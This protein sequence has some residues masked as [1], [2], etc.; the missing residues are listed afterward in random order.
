MAASKQY[1]IIKQIKVP[2]QGRVRINSIP[3]S[4]SYSSKFKSLEDIANEKKAKLEAKNYNIYEVQAFQNY[5]NYNKNTNYATVLDSM[6]NG[7][8]QQKHILNFLGSLNLLVKDNSIQNNSQ[9]NINQKKNPFQFIQDK[10]HLQKSLTRNHQNNNMKSSNAYDHT[11][12]VPRRKS[13]CCRRCGIVPVNTLQFKTLDY[14]Q[15]INQHY[16]EYLKTLELIL[17]EQDTQVKIKK[18]SNG[19]KF[20]KSKINNAVQYSRLKKDVTSN[21]SNN[22]SQL[23]MI[24]SGQYSKGCKKSTYINISFQSD[25]SQMQDSL[26]N[27][28]Q[29]LNLQQVQ[30]QSE[31]Q[32]Q[33]EYQNQE[34]ENLKLQQ[35]NQQKLLNINNVTQNISSKNM[36]LQNQEKIKLEQNS[37][38][39][40]ETDQEQTPENKKKNIK[41]STKQIFTLNQ[42]Q[43][44]LIQQEISKNVINYSNFELNNVN[45]KE[46]IEAK[47]QQINHK[48]YNKQAYFYVKEKFN[49][50]QMSI[51]SQ[52]FPHQE[53][54][55]IKD[56]NL[57]GEN[58]QKL[59]ENKLIIDTKNNKKENFMQT[60]I[61]PIISGTRIQ[62]LEGPQ[63]S[64]KNVQQALLGYRKSQPA[65]EQVKLISPK[66]R[67]IDFNKNHLETKTKGFQKQNE[68]QF[69]KSDKQTYSGF[70]DIISQRQSQIIEENKQQKQPIKSQKKAKKSIK[71]QKK[72]QNFN[73]TYYSNQYSILSRPSTTVTNNSTFNKA[74][75]Q[76]KSQFVNQNTDSLQGK[77]LYQQFQSREQC[78]HNINQK[79]KNSEQDK[80]LP[81]RFFHPYK[82]S[83]NSFENEKKCAPSLYVQSYVKDLR[84]ENIR[85]KLELDPLSTFIDNK[86]M[87][88]NNESGE[89]DESENTQYIYNGQQLGIGADQKIIPKLLNYYKDDE[90][91]IPEYIGNLPTDIEKISKEISEQ[92]YNNNLEND[93]INKAQNLVN[94]NLLCPENFTDFFSDLK[95]MKSGQLNSQKSYQ[96]FIEEQKIKAINQD[97]LEEYSITQS[98]NQLINTQCT[99]RELAPIARQLANIQNDGNSDKNLSL[100]T[101]EEFLINFDQVHWQD[102]V[103]IVSGRISNKQLNQIIKNKNL[104]NS[105][106]DQQ[107]EQI[108]NNFGNANVQRE[109]DASTQSNQDIISLQQGQLYQQKLTSKEIQFKK[110]QGEYNA[111]NITQKSQGI[112]TDQNLLIQVENEY[113]EKEKNM[114]KQLISNIFGQTDYILKEIE[115]IKSKKIQYQDVLQKKEAAS[116]KKDINRKMEHLLTQLLSVI[117]YD[118]PNRLKNQDRNY[119]KVNNKI[120][121]RNGNTNQFGS[122]KNLLVLQ[123]TQ[124]QSSQGFESDQQEEISNKKV[125]KMQKIINSPLQQINEHENDL[126]IMQEMHGVNK[127]NNK[128]NILGQQQQLTQKNPRKLVKMKTV[129][130]F[131]TENDFQQN[132]KYQNGSINNNAIYSSDDEDSYKQGNQS[133][134]QEI[135]NKQNKNFNQRQ[136]GYEDYSDEEPKALVYH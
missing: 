80:N 10:D 111:Q 46:K 114:N 125:I 13:C 70:P 31:F 98:K 63:T 3:K 34:K 118:A 132:S 39:E 99:Y 68:S 66:A 6:Q 87:N 92:V 42:Q 90:Q 22:N 65:L 15:I 86:K 35:Q 40:Q 74:T 76:K 79:S 55:N 47:D 126:N 115:Q 101:E 91:S 89:K 109:N 54:Q 44:Q 117:V 1:G 64:Q 69:F 123:K 30:N 41:K 136:M 8:T 135:I 36:Q 26:Q 4:F 59:K 19:N 119:Q 100:I 82:S 48:Q 67:Y 124:T 112:Q 94:N 23:E 27:N 61:S 75:Q 29:Q 81:F 116:L 14:E 84:K 120:T 113:K 57:I 58:F 2:T 83:G 72:Y 73:S 71:Q 24:Q 11:F 7:Q 106:K 133:D 53:Q 134:N 12:K 107:Y 5:L 50:N 108:Q 20:F 102:I 78:S 17:N 128:N 96:D 85:S 131:Q 45:Q 105:D 127:D 60:E 122:K 9:A 104:V 121:Q 52:I 62:T 16:Q 95:K 56:Q 43:Q 49:K 25:I 103:N 97:Y 18:A 38:L 33:Q 32:N 77:S 110:V 51:L 129:G 88:K 37:F 28:Q 130:N 93:N 21:N